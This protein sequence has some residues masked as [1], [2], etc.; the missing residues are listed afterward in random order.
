MLAWQ[1]NYVEWLSCLIRMAI[2]GYGTVYG[3][4]PDQAVERLAE[5]MMLNDTVALKNKVCHSHGAM[6]FR[7]TCVKLEA[8]VLTSSEL[9]SSTRL[10]VRME[11]SVPGATLRCQWKRARLL[12]SLVNGM[13]HVHAL[14]SRITRISQRPKVRGLHEMLTSCTTTRFYQ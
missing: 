1:L 6:V 8:Q 10:P 7:A 13:F 3:I 12:L 4:S 11:V 9:S 2:V 14:S 5:E